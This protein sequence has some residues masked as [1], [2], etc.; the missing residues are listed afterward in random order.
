MRAR[1]P[2]LPYLD[3]HRPIDGVLLAD[4][5]FVYISLL[6]RLHQFFLSHT[7]ILAV[8]YSF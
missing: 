8:G 3:L 4:G 1:L 2:S 5:C 6:Y 7:L